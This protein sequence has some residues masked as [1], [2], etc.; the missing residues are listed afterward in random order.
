MPWEYR[1]NLYMRISKRKLSLLKFMI[2]YMHFNLSNVYLK[3]ILKMNLE[4]PLVS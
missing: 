4:K 1:F 3:N 2:K